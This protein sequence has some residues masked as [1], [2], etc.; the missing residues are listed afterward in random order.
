MTINDGMNAHDLNNLSL[1]GFVVYII[2]HNL[3]F[4]SLRT[5]ESDFFQ[6][7][8]IQTTYTF[9]IPVKN[10]KHNIL[11]INIHIRMLIVDD[12]YIIININ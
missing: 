11:K 3:F 5:R 1:C 6:H 2:Q 7:T 12:I 4:N 9:N 8:C 10:V